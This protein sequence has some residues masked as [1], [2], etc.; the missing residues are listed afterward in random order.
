[1]YHSL[2]YFLSKVVISFILIAVLVSVGE[3]FRLSRHQM[4]CLLVVWGKKSECTIIYWM[5]GLRHD[6]FYYFFI[7]IFILFLTAWTT[8]VSFRSAFLALGFIHS[9]IHSF[10]LVLLHIHLNLRLWYLLSAPSPQTDRWL[11]CSL[12]C[13][14]ASSS[15]FPAST[16]TL[17]RY[18]TTMSGPNTPHSPR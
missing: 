2:P 8:E 5:V 10:I 9:F 1:M 6:K 7:F 15:Y 11:K 4:S 14:W 18:L 16:S 3:L 12:A 13:V 17:T